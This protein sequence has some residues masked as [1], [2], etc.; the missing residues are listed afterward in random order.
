MK[1]VN[2]ISAER[3][4]LSDYIRKVWK[5][6]SLIITFAKRDLKVK[7]AQTFLGIFWILLQPIP[8]VVIFAFF[9]GRLMN[10]DT[11][12]LPYAVF[13]LTGMIGWNYF[14]NLTSSIGNSLID[15]QHI[16][17]KI[18]FPKIILPLSKVLVGGVDFLV[19][20]ALIILA[21]LFFS[22]FPNWKIIF[23]PLFFLFNILTGFCI[24]IWISSL[25]FRYRDFQHVA[26]YIINFCIWL[27]PVFYP[28]TLLPKQFT[29]LMYLNPMAFVIEGYRFTLVGDKAPSPYF[30]ISVIPVLLLFVLG[31]LYFRK[32][33]DEIADF[34]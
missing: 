34:I 14:T 27:T 25:T 6:R 24:G 4:A 19:S 2:I 8:S 28:I 22:V 32:I 31:L 11:G 1:E 16:L 33:E 18:Y 20:F 29:S 10:A 3:D 21:M 17:K 15:S 9:F 23:F 13:A 7:Y 5:Y 26:P 12:M 30:L